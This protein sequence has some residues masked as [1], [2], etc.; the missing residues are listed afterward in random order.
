MF[1]SRFV[2]SPRNQ[3]GGAIFGG[4]VQSRSRLLGC[5]ADSSSALMLRSRLRSKL[6]RQNQP[7]YYIL[8]DVLVVFG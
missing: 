3:V 2:R 5:S 4:S 6:K 8:W 7:C 1:Y